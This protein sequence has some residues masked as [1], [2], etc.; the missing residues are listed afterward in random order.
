VSYPGARIMPAGFQFPPPLRGRYW[1]TYAQDTGSSKNQ[2]GY[3]W[4]SVSRP[5]AGVTPAQAG[6]DM[7]VIARLLAKQYPGT[8]ARRLDSRDAGGERSWRS[9]RALVI[10]LAVAAGSADEPASNSRTSRWHANLARQQR[11]SPSRRMGTPRE[12]A[13][14][15]NFSPRACWC[16]WRRWLNWDSPCGETQGPARG[17]SARIPRDGEVGIDGHVLGVAGLPLIARAFCGLIRLG[18]VDAELEAVLREARQSCGRASRRHFRDVLVVLERA[19]P[20]CWLSGAGLLIASYLRLMHAGPASRR[21]MSSR[22]GPELAAN[23]SILP[24]RNLRFMTI[25]RPACDSCR[26]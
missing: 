18:K 20:W 1:A 17:D 19:G 15:R 12:A 23:R 13:W 10:L 14:W 25:C 21:A 7:D 11:K 3:N 9:R 22:S 4:L 6:A 16:L 24:R 26:R 5:K 2:R 8:N